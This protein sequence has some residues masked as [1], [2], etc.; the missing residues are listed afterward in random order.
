MSLPSD[1]VAANYKDA[2]E[3]LITNERHQ[4]AFLTGIAQE[5]IEHAQAI[6]TALTTHIKK[7]SKSHQPPMSY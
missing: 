2:L 5:N 6:A 1:E 7:V 3:D 4:I